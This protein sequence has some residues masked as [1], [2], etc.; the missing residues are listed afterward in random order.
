MNQ[1]LD[2]N[3]IL[4]TQQQNEDM[5]KISGWAA[6]VVGPTLI[7]SIYGMNFDVMPELHWR[8][9]YVYSLVLMVVVAAVIWLF[10]KR[11]KWM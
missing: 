3:S 10:F 5:K 6:V 4:V 9:G 11:K 8:F 1:I 7:G 2:V